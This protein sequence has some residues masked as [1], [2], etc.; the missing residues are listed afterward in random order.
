MPNVVTTT[1]EN[2]R[3]MKTKKILPPLLI[4]LT[5]FISTCQKDDTPPC[6]YPKNAKLKQ[7]V[8]CFEPNLECP[9]IECD[10]SIEQ[11]YEY[12]NKGRIRKVILAHMFEYHLYDYNAE[13]KLVNIEYYST[14]G[15]EYVHDRNCVFTYSEDGKKIREYID[16]MN[17]DNFQYSLFE[18]TNNR[19]SRTNIY[20]INS[21]ELEYYILYEY[22]DSGNL[23]LETQYNKYDVPLCETKHFYENGLNVETNDHGI[24]ILKTYDENNNLI[25]L[26]TFYQSGS[27]KGNESLKYEYNF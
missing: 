14:Y 20:E 19:L 23:V 2:R 15:D 24:Q 21:D 4:L 8:N 9:T 17:S 18:Y 7:I 26:E 3:I 11:E 1:L 12:D 13:G 10:G 27:S 22:D 25:L 6:S 16:W 5:I